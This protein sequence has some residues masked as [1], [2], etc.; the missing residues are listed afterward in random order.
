M[1][2][3]KGVLENFTKLTGNTCARISSLIKLE[4]WVLQLYN[5]ETLAQMF[6]CEFYE[7]FKNSIFYGTLSVTA[8]GLSNTVMQNNNK[9]KKKEK[10]QNNAELTFHSN[11]TYESSIIQ[12]QY[13][14]TCCITLAKTRNNLKPSDITWNHL[15]LWL[16]INYS[17]GAFV[18]IRWPK[19]IFRQIWAQKLKFF[20]LTEIW[21]KRAWLYPYFEFNVYFFQSSF[22]EKFGPKLWSPPNWLKFCGWVHCYMLFTILM[23]IFSKFCNSYNFGQIWSPNLMFSKLTEIW[24]KS[25]LLCADYGFDV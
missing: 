2:C 19:V 4:A 18:L 13:S 23:F 8:S 7:I 22:Q 3:K 5:K 6:S 9:G 15:Y 14:F 12:C 20:K 16:K 11:L 1:F 10:K 17:Q 24:Y 25:T 21:Y